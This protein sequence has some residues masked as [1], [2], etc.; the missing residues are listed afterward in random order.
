MKNRMKRTIKDSVFTMLFAIPENVMALYRALHPED[1]TIRPEDLTTI[2]LETAL[3]TSIYNDLGLQVRET[4]VVLIEAQSTF[5]WNLPFRLL[6]YL[7]ETLDNYVI[8]HK[9]NRYAKKPIKI[10]RPELYVVYSGPEDVPPVIRLSDLF[11]DKPDNAEENAK[12][13][14]EIRQKYGWVEIEVRIIRKTGKGD[15]LD[16]YV[17]FCEI[18]DKIREEYG[19]T[20]E[21][22]RKTIELCIAQGVL[23]EFISSRRTEVETNMWHMFDEEAALRA[24]EAEIWEEGKKEGKKEGTR[25][26]TAEVTEK[27]ICAMVEVLKGLAQTRES[28]VKVIEDKFS[29]QPQV[30]AEKVAR[31]WK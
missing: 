2:T 31:Y 22:V 27:S 29:L 30:A 17:R 19:P 15:I 20:I 10:P 14:Q 25:E 16:Q 24:H 9:M 11:S 7:A 1:D 26:A 8:T 3:V 28:V 23:A 12:R 21:A 18:S 4:I 6:L 13:Q 5:S